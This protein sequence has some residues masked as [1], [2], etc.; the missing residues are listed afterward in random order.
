MAF[1][2]RVRDSVII[3]IS[4]WWV[5]SYVHVFILLSSVVVT[6]TTLAVCL[7]DCRPGIPGNAKPDSGCVL[8][9]LGAFIDHRDRA[10]EPPR[11]V[12]E[13]LSPPACLEVYCRPR[14]TNKPHGYQIQWRRRRSGHA[15]PFTD[16][17]R[18][19]RLRSP[20]SAPVGV[21]PAT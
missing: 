2:S 18:Q 14:R 9:I 21:S 7:T 17:R 15:L 13:H 19:R 8:K 1:S 20:A 10:Y 16:R 3:R 11:R 12:R 4:V 5:S 6:L